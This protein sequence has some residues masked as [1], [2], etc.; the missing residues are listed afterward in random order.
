MQ[1]RAANRKIFQRNFRIFSILSAGYV[2]ESSMEELYE[3]VDSCR[4]NA[5]TN[6]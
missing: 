5:R 2:D 1:L 3:K 6:I 4:Y